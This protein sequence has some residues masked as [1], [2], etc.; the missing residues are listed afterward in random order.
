[1]ASAQ[2]VL[3]LETHR[4]LPTD[5]ADRAVVMPTEEIANLP[6]TVELTTVGVEVVAWAAVSGEQVLRAL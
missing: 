1:M 3:L 6:I 2:A 4:I 5:V